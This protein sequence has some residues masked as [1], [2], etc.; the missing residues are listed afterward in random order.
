MKK[1]VLLLVTVVN[2]AVAAPVLAE[3]A[4]MIS[5]TLESGPCSGELISGF[6]IDLS[7]FSFGFGVFHLFLDIDFCY[8][9]CEYDMTD[10]E[11]EHFTLEFED[12]DC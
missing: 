7:D 5:C 4:P 1:K 12:F 6:S 10:A 8:N 3:C 2:L 11:G 9:W